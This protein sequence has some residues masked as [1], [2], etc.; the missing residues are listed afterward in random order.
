M[1]APR[2]VA[3]GSPLTADSALCWVLLWHSVLR[4]PAATCGP[5]KVVGH[6]GD[7]VY[8]G[9]LHASAL[10]PAT[11]RLFVSLAPNKTTTAIGVIDLRAG[12]LTK[13][14]HE[15]QFGYLVG[16]KWDSLKKRLVGVL[17]SGGDIELHQLDPVS[18]KYTVT[19]L[20]GY[21]SVLGNEGTACAF[22]DASGTLYAMMTKKNESGA[23]STHLVPVYVRQGAIGVPSPV[24]EKV[25]VGLTLQLAM[26]Q[27]PPAH[28]DQGAKRIPF[29]S[30]LFEAK[31][32]C[33][34]FGAE[35]AEIC[36]DQLVFPQTLDHFRFSGAP[37]P[38]WSQRYLQN[39]EYWGKGSSPLQMPAGCPGP[40]LLY[41]GNEGPIDA[42]WG[43]NGFMIHHLAPLW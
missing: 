16:V 39:G 21:D 13:V 35:D 3:Q 29:A 8:S 33:A 42:F 24:M 2:A 5:F 12:K 41:T 25:G 4:G 22:D 7:A 11:Q 30:Q 26:A 23:E 9:L 19:Q 38:T 14:I 15:D 34:K 17:G 36:A 1:A 32:V 18:E 10:D 37:R 6:F 43:S 40:I 31:Q 20:G 28:E 27:P